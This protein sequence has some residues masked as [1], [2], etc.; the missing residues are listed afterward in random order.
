MRAA[1]SAAQVSTDLNVA[2]AGE[3][4]LAGRWPARP[5]RAGTTDRCSCGVRSSS[6]G[7]PRRSASSTWSKRSAPGCSSSASS[8]VVVGGRVAAC[9]S[10]S[11]ERSAFANAC[12]NVRP[13]AIASPTDFMWV[14]Q[15]R[16]G[17]RELLERE[18]RPLDHAVVDRR[19]EARRRR[20][21]DVVGDLL[22]RVADGEPGGDLRDREARSPCSPAR[23]SATRAGSSRSP[24]SRRSRGLTANWT[25]EPPVSTPTAR[26]AAIAWSRSAWYCLSVSVCCGRDADAV[27]GVHA[28]RVEVL[29]RADDHDVVGA[30][31][32]HLELELAPPE[33][34]LL[35]QH[36]ADRRRLQAA[37][38]DRV[39]LGLGCGRRRRPCRRA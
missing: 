6:T 23:S 36:L 27:A 13:I 1:N 39:E 25:F 12:L 38:D 19:L 17:A 20:P 34:R 30:V 37:A 22:E 4:R 15:P 5:A 2:L 33:H 29:D 16:L 11:R 8:V 3:R 35:E 7:V 18:P 21:G 10:S 24:R 32:H 28:H 26:I 14:R 31:A 9:E